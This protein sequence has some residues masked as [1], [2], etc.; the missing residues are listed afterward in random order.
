MILEKV[1]EHRL[2]IFVHNRLGPFL[3]YNIKQSQLFVLPMVI[4]WFPNTL[5]YLLVNCWLAWDLWQTLAALQLFYSVEEHV[6]EDFRDFKYF[7]CHWFKFFFC[8]RL[9]WTGSFPENFLKSFVVFFY[10]FLRYRF[11]LWVEELWYHFSWHY[12]LLLHVLW[13]WNLT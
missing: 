1:R 6:F 8:Q 11:A 2:K 3:G 12:S 4:I 9:S 5:Y 13:L 10:D 7:C